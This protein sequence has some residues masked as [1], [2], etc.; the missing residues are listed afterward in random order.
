MKSNFIIVALTVIILTI[1][2]FLLYDLHNSSENEIT[3]RF[4]AQQ[5]T[6]ANQ[7]AR[8]IKSFLCKRAQGIEIL[9]SLTSLQQQEMKPL[10]SD[11]Q[12]YFGHVKDNNVKAI[13]VYDEKGTILYSTAKAVIGRNY[14]QLDYFQW[15]MKKENKGKQFISSLIQKTDNKTQ[16]LAY[17]R[18]LIVSPIY[19]VQANKFVGIITETIDLKEVLTS[20]LPLVSP[21]TAKEN[22]WI[23]DEDG[24]VLFQSEHPEMVLRNIKQRDQSCMKCHTSFDYVE[25]ILTAKKGNFG[26]RLKEKPKKLASFTSLEF[27]NISWTIVLNLPSEEVTGFLA[28]QNR[29]TLILIG[30][31]ALVL[32]GGSLKIYQ[33]NRL[34]VK[35]EENVKELREKQTFNLILESAGEGIFGLDLNGYHTFVNPAAAALLGYKIEELVGKHSHSI[36]HYALPTGEPYPCE[37][38]HIYATLHDGTSHSGEEYFWRKDRTGF[39]VDFSTTPVLENDKVIGAVVIFR[40]ITERK[41]MEISLLQQL[42]FSKALNEIANIIVSSE[43]SSAILE[44]TT[45]ILG[46]ALSVARCLIYDANFTTNKLTAFSER[47]DPKSSDIKP[48]KGVYPIDVFISGITEMRKTKQYLTS[49][50]DNINPVLLKDHSDK[51]LHEQMSI[52]SALWYPFAFYPDGYHLLV[53]NETHHKREWTNEEVNFLDSVS[54]QVSIALEKIRLL[55]AKK[56][57]EVEIKMLATS[58][59]RINECVSITDNEN[60][61]LFVNE[62]FLKTYG[63]SEEEVLGKNITIVSSLNSPLKAVGEVLPATLQGG[64]NGELINRRK[65]GSEFPIYLSTTIIEKK[66]GKPEYLIGIAIDI[67]ERKQ[68]EREL[69]KAKEKAENANSVKDGFIQNISHEIRTPLNGILGMTSVIKEIFSPY[70]T[71]EEATFFEAIDK[72]SRRIIRTVDMILNFS[73]LQSNDFTIAP[74]EINL[75]SICEKLCAE[76]QEAAKQAS[77]EL[78]Y[79]DNLGDVILYADEYTVTHSIS[80]LLDNAIRFTKKGFVKVSLFAGTNNEVKLEIKDSGIGIKEAYLEHLFEP[81]RQEDMGYSR[82]YEGVGLGLPLAKKFLELNNASISVVSKKGEGTTFTIAFVKTMNPKKEIAVPKK[83]I[84]NSIPAVRERNETVLI[85]E[86]DL[87]NRNMIT[88]FLKGYYH[89]LSVSSSDEAL[90]TLKTNSVDII[91]MDISIRGSKNGLELTEELK[92]LKEYQLIPVIAV[93]AHAFDQDRKNASEAG[94]DAFLPKPFTKESLLQIIGKFI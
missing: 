19:Q 61:I 56:H 88:R 73:R 80:D 50:F 25:R 10:I 3:N 77:L 78:T 89:S 74:Q 7:I 32:I 83:I 1:I 42:N 76:F 72:S 13:S 51:I 5:L 4:N 87:I 45:D 49:H 86:D 85:V 58:L 24:T 43:D 91:L 15:A 54:H 29:S 69:I 66:D 23:L 55:E 92:A 70:I 68:A 36:W 52:K 48:T 94:C 79:E 2:T 82:A 39:P 75:S 9:S 6:A 34:K 28:K 16:P 17:F 63:Y 44:K 20:F 18:F 47:L 37:D 33:S 8:E 53:L 14:R 57:S 81:Y 59:K 62:A 65:D 90:H 26:Y 84:N 40:D 41:K 22:V 21:Y 93:T 38:C 67:T 46:E 30:L 31:I 12:N 71:E 27:K 60:T 35:A 11:I 64:W